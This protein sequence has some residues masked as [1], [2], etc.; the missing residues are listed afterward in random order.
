MEHEFEFFKN[1]DEAFDF[2]QNSDYFDDV[3]RSNAYSWMYGE[4][5]ERAAG[6]YN[7][8]SQKIYIFPFNNRP[9]MFTKPLYKALENIDLDISNMVLEKLENMVMNFQ[10]D[11][12]NHE[13][14][15]KVIRMFLE[16]DISVFYEELMVENL[17]NV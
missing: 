14:L 10:M 7:D 4:W 11:T 8:S 6:V 9:Y 16:E 17:L 5:Y 1:R 12:F 2:I 3:D 13:Y 15:H